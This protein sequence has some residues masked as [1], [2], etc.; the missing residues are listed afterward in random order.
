VFRR[1]TQSNE[2]W[3]SELRIEQSDIAHLYELLIDRGAPMRTD[4]LAV[5]FVDFRCRSEEARIREELS[6]GTLYQPKDDFEVGERLVFPAL[7]FAAG[8]VVEK[9]AGANPEH[10]DFHVV[11]VK[12]DGRRKAK[13]YASALQ[14]AHKLNND[15]ANDD[16]LQAEGLLGPAELLV[17][18]APDLPGKLVDHLE[19]KEK[20][21]FIRGGDQW[22]L[23]D[24][25][26]DF[27]VGH[28]NIAEA[29]VEMGGEPV[30]TAKLLR[31]MDCS[32]DQPDDVVLF[33]LNHALESDGRFDNL[34]TE[35]ERAWFLKRLEPEDA[36]QTPDLLKLEPSEYDRS[37]L[38][39][40]LLRLEW[41]LGDEWSENSASTSSAAPTVT[42]VL[43]YPHLHS[44]TL[45]LS[46]RTQSVFPAGDAKRGKMVFID[47]RWGQ[48][49]DGW[50]VRDGRYVTGLRDW[51]QSHKVPVG[52]FIVLERGPEPGE[53]VVDFRPRRMRREW[54]RFARVVDEV[55]VFEMRKL[56]I[57]C[58][59][60]EMMVVD[61]LNAEE[62]QHLR[63]I[64]DHDDLSLEEL[65]RITFPE[66]LK[67]N[68]EGNVHAKTVYSAVNLVRRTPPGPLFALL[69]TSDVY[70]DDG[71]G[72][73]SLA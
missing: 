63:E 54:A 41:E 65:L 1:R 6:K 46:S 45:P 27:G 10:G 17:S 8:T 13:E 71:S 58:E 73:W 3:E 21:Q 47:G 26:A 48:R 2:Y 42:I 50:M 36:V 35:D 34:G 39:A 18:M 23:K 30:P 32:S 33:S 60:D 53:V 25:L 44:G 4:E 28:L 15:N 19:G 69:S 5:A 29:V 64:R 31:G 12:F 9:R 70:R 40:E 57:A 56:P 68:P 24:M 66:L 49:F 72:Y 52:A 16:V 20:Q 43:T 51:Y 22:L 37:E 7:D 61:A 38:N 55:L 59:Y 67:L 11:K 62:I 14:T